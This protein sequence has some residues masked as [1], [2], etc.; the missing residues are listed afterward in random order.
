MIR[1]SIW[2]IHVFGNDVPL[3]CNSIA[4]FIAQ[5]I[6]LTFGLCPHK[7][8][9]IRRLRHGTRINHLVCK[10]IYVKAFWYFYFYF[11]NGLGRVGL[12]AIH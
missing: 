10:Y 5:G 7:Q 4:I 1:N 9:S 6:N 12:V 3:F 2:S 11:S 8:R